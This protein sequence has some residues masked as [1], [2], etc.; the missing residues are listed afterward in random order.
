DAYPGRI[1]ARMRQGADEAFAEHIIGEPDDGDGPGC[2]LRGS[3][4]GRP[5]AKN[6]VNLGLNQLCSMFREFF[7]QQSI[8]LSVDLEIAALDETTPAQR[9]VK[10]D[11]VRIS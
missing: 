8:T 6:D 10:R 2:L 7:R 5:A 3:D 1:T 4:S 9:V 11:M